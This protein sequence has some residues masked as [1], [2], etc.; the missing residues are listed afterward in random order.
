MLRIAQL[1]GLQ[2]DRLPCCNQGCGYCTGSR[3]PL[4]NSLAASTQRVAASSRAGAPLRAGST[5]SLHFTGALQQS[6]KLP[7]SGSRMQR[8]ISYTQVQPRCIPRATCELS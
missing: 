8:R 2:H 6:S 4:P 1:A 5:S 7:P 3:F